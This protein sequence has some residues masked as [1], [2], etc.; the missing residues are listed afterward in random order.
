MSTKVLVAFSSRHGATD[1]LARMIGATIAA[2]GPSV[3]IR[4]MEDVDTVFP[5]GALVLGSAVYLGRWTGEARRFIDLHEE[6]IVARPTWLF[7]SGPIGD[8]IGIEQFD[9]AELVDRTKARDHHLFGGRLAKRSLR[10]GERAIAGLLGA[11]DG[12]YRDWPTAA[13]W[14]TAIARTLADEQAA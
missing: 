14:A 3:E 2:Q 9:A 5:Y 11:Q 4:R 7:S 8:D 1:E 6:G 12:D 13:A 10:L